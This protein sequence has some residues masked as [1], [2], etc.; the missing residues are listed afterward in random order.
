MS[1]VSALLRKTL[2]SHQHAGQLIRSCSQARWAIAHDIGL[3]GWMAKLRESLLLSCCRISGLWV[4]RVSR[5][6]LPPSPEVLS[7]FELVLAEKIKHSLRC[8]LDL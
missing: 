4:G 6:Q 7:W 3:L 5:A 1:P 8:K 2:L